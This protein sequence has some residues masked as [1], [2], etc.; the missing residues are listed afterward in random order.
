MLPGFAC[1][2][3]HVVGNH[4]LDVKSDAPRYT[5]LRPYYRT[6]GPNYYSFNYL[7]S[8]FIVLDVMRAK[9]DVY[10][11]QLAWLAKDLALFSGTHHII[12]LSHNIS[13]GWQPDLKRVFTPYRVLAELAGHQHFARVWEQDRGERGPIACIQASVFNPGTGGIDG[14]DS[15]Y[16][17]VTVKDGRINTRMC[18]LGKAT[19]IDVIGERRNGQVWIDGPVLRVR[20]CD[21]RSAVIRCEHR[22]GGGD[23]TALESMGGALWQTHVDTGG[24]IEIRQTSRKGRTTTSRIDLRIR[25]H[26]PSDRIRTGADWPM[27]QHDPLHTGRSEDA[28]RAPLRL[29]W[30]RA[31]AEHFHLASPIIADGKVIVGLP[32]EGIDKGGVLALDAGTGR[33]VWRHRT[34]AAVRHTPCFANGRVVFSTSSGE[35]CCLNARTGKKVWGRQGSLAVQMSHAVVGDV[36][37]AGTDGRLRTYRLDTG[38]PIAAS[39]TTGWPYASYVSPAVGHGRAYYADC[40]SLG[41]FCFDRNLKTVWQWVTKLGKQRPCSH[42]SV[43]IHQDKVFWPVNSHV[44]ALRPDTGEVIWK[45]SLGPERIVYPTPVSTPCVSGDRLFVGSEATGTLTA[46]DTATGRVVWEYRTGR[47]LI[48]YGN[49]ANCYA[50][51]IFGSPVVSGDVVYVGGADGCLHGVDARTGRPVC[52]YRIGTPITSSPAVSGNTIVVTGRDGWVYA[53][54]GQATRTG[55]P[56]TQR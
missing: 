18:F 37:Y 31:C 45:R 36:L 14:V 4:D 26:G 8:H 22:Y 55:S 42:A 5:D 19:R 47:S 20:C 1:P 10:K 27:F 33:E 24:A 17:A 12:V 35:T 3:Y 13:L 21:D 6:L 54:T 28:V 43:V 46:L 2:T 15:G 32:N 50:P 25:A 56:A 53:F 38:Q 30:T 7:D 51:A 11:A 23:W 29:R 34:R 16:L 9:D 41:L 48:P 39:V 44:F 49:R 52:W 40:A